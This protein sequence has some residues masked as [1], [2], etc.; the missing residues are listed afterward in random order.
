MFVPNLPWLETAII[1]PLVASVWVRRIDRRDQARLHKLV[2]TSLSLIAS[3]FAWQEFKCR[4][5]SMPRLGWDFL[6]IDELSSPLF[7]LA[8]LLF[9][10]F[11][12]ATVRTKL[13]QVSYSRRLFSEAIVLATFASKNHWQ[14]VALLLLGSLPPFLEYRQRS[15][16]VGT[17]VFHMALF[18]G[19]LVSGSIGLSLS[20]AQSTLR[21]VP[22]GLL[23]AAILIRHGVF[24]LHC[25]VTDLVENV[26][27]GTAILFLTPMV[28]AYAAMRLI[29]PSAPIWELQWFALLSLIT[30]VYAAGM[31]MVQADTRRYFCYLFLSNSSLVW[32]GLATMTPI[33]LTGGLAIWLAA[34]LSLSGIGMTLRAIESRMG[35]LS[36]RDYHGLYEH[37][38]LLA[39]FFLLAGLASAGFPGTIGFVAIDLLFDGVNQIYR[40][41]GAAVVLATALNGISVLK[42]YF[43]LFTGKR[44]VASISLAP[45]WSE[46]VAIIMLAAMMLILGLAPQSFLLSRF[47]AT[48]ELLNMRTGNIATDKH[49]NHSDLQLLPAT[50]H[51]AN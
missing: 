37:M 26:T 24:P 28:S 43:R 32:V 10:L 14:L 49:S 15:K 21:F 13:I 25:W 17:Y 36:L 2:A 45:R 50:L 20:D 12:L 9:V 11:V 18:G 34:I 42:I 51:S 3:C 38:P 39:V 46:R 44:H 33:G 6:I 16:R 5:N 27:F 1:I 19:L 22:I 8:S 31:A 40:Y 35:R 29:L 23:L 30:A 47:E 41:V 7:P 48:N 4:G